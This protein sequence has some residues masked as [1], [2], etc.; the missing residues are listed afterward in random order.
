MDRHVRGE[1]YV[2]A[3][4]VA[5]MDEMRDRDDVKGSSGRG[6]VL[7]KVAGASGVGG[8]MQCCW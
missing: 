4:L 5:S 1:E 8:G 6:E 2:G 3:G 7:R